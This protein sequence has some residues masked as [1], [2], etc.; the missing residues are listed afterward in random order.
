MEK[1][2]NEVGGRGKVHEEQSDRAADAPVLRPPGRLVYQDEETSSGITCPP[3]TEDEEDDRGAASANPIC[4]TDTCGVFI[5]SVP[6]HLHPSLSSSSSSSSS[7]VCL[8][9]PLPPSVELASVLADTRL[10]LDVYKGG[11]AA[12]L[13][14]WASIP[15]QLMGVQYLTLGS[16]DREGLGDALD[17]VPRLTDLRTLAIRGTVVKAS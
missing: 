10:T 8:N 7:G 11:A 2:K 6:K 12:L 3:Q 16:D 1:S 17:V 14:L 5:P 4:S 9:P 15:E 13:L